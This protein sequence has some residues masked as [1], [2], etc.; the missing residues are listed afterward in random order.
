MRRC[1]EKGKQWIRTHRRSRRHAALQNLC[2]ALF[3][4]ALCVVLLR[5]YAASNSVE[6]AVDK[7]CEENLFGEAEILSILTYEEGKHN[8]KEVVI[9]KE[10]SNGDRYEAK[11]FMS[12]KNPLKWENTGCSY[13][14]E[15]IDY[16][17]D[18]TLIEHW[19]NDTNAFYRFSGKAVQGIFPELVGAVWVDAV[20]V[21][22]YVMEGMEPGPD[23][24]MSLMVGIQ[25]TETE[26]SKHRQWEQAELTYWINLRTMEV[27][28]I[29]FHLTTVDG[30]TAELWMSE[31]RM[32]FIA[33]KLMEALPPTNF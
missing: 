22:T 25:F 23:S 11:L 3:L 21:P 2:F 24:H 6:A 16:A 28:K 18:R 31:E 8:Q 33:E 20:F 13:F 29:D 27:K 26:D 9:G 10:L 12:K 4:T 5:G 15:A 14:T 17:V 30:K 32:E 19:E 7:W 1:L